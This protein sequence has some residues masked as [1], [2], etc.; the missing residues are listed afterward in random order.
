MLVE[1]DRLGSN[2]QETLL[3]E[4]TSEHGL[5]RLH[6]EAVLEEPDLV[7]FHVLTVPEVIQ[8]RDWVRV[9]APQPVVLEVAGM[10]A[11]RGACD[12]VSGGGMLL[13]GARDPGARRPRPLSTAPGRSRPPI[14]GR[15]RVVR[16]GSA[17]QRGIVF[18]EISRKDRERLIHFIFDRQRVERA[19]TR[20]DAL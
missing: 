14:R 12:R 8:R 3:F 6:G 10:A 5:A 19:R 18:E 2:P 4:S 11:D 20:G 1:P 17:E 9:L 15:G 16:Y 7:R 13:V